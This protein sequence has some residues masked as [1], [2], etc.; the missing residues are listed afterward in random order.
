MTKMVDFVLDDHSAK[1]AGNHYDLRLKYPTRN[2]LASWALTKHSIPKRTSEK[3]LAVKTQDHDM[4]W[5]KFQG[6]IPEGSFGAG[7]VKIVQRGQAEIL[8]WTRDLISF[9]VNGS[10]M[11]G[12][13]NLVKMKKSTGKQENWLLLKGKDD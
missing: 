8:T 13:Y 2:K 7:T 11:N 12:K 10:V 6:K 1:H 3:V 4:S 9:K 5:L